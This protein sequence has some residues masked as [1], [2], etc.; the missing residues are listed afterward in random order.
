LR[1]FKTVKRERMS[2]LFV[3]LAGWYQRSVNSTLAKYGLRYEDLLVN[4]HPDVV[5]AL[6]YI[7]EEE[8]VN[9][10]RRIRRA[11]ILSLRHEYLPKEIQAIQTPGKSYMREAMEEQRKI[12]EERE[13]LT[14]F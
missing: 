7:P 14:N 5:G 13:R 8:R 1:C 4:D 9:R 6:K 3:R 11:M 10:E 12:R 2:A